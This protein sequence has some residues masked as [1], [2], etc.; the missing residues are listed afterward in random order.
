LVVSGQ[1]E[2][3]VEMKG[4]MAARGVKY[5]WSCTQPWLPHQGMEEGAAMETKRRC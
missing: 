1:L 2:I 5:G 4:K 3:N